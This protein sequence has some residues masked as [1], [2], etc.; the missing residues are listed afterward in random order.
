MTRKTSTK[1]INLIKSFEGYRAN[2][3]LDAVGVPTIGYGTTRGVKMGQKINESQAVAFLQKDL[4]MFE[5]AINRLVK[6]PLTQDQ[7]DALSSFV[8][9][10]GETNFAGSTLLKVINQ[11][12]YD[13]APAQFL[14]WNKAG[15]KVLNGLTRR[16]Q[17]E[18]NLFSTG[19]V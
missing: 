8:Y 2:A 12:R 10:L 16:R 1:G 15:G 6:V 11:G 5:N 19:K 7:F 14:R 18:A 17:A 3:Y 4:E 13:L 9:N